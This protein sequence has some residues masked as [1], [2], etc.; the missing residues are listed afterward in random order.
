M[1]TLVEDL[2]RIEEAL[3]AISKEH[4][5]PKVRAAL[6]R[7]KTAVE[8]AHKAFSGSWIGYH[9]HVYYKGLETPPPGANFSSQWGF[10]DRFSNDTVGEW[11]EVDGD[12]LLEHLK[13]HARSPSV[14]ELIDIGTEAAEQSKDLREE[15]LSILDA[16]LSRSAD[17]YL[18]KLKKLTQEARVLR[19]QDAINQYRPTGQ[20]LCNDHA[21]MSGKQRVPPHILLQAQI[22]TIESC[23]GIPKGL[24]AV[25][26]RAS[27]HLGKKEQSKGIASK[28][29]NKIFIGHGGSDAW[30]QL[31]DFLEDTLELEV[32]EFNR[33]PIAGFTNIARLSEM[34]DDAVIAFLVMTAEDEQ[35]DGK[36]HARMNVIHEAGLFQG[37]LGFARAIIVL[38]EGCEEFSNIQGLGQI[39]FPPKKIKTAFQEIR[40][41][42]ERENIVT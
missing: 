36:L 37:R 41:V 40:E 9:S 31:K 32:D 33:K 7:L 16:C 4:D 39:R 19:A 21:A 15:L 42:L 27:S 18:S 10:Q 22:E 23:L 6:Q 28:Q 38:E 3:G 29:G 12:K 14:E 5:T 17:E 25:A 30:R 34:L 13:S 8:D 20:F 24:S 2:R 11:V 26:R 1:P 35:K